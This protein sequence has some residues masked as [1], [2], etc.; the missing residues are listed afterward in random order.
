MIHRLF[1]AG[2]NL[3]NLYL[4]ESGSVFSNGR[5]YRSHLC[6]SITETMCWCQT[7]PV[8]G[9]GAKM[10]F[11]RHRGQNVF[12]APERVLRD[13][14]SSW[15]HQDV[16]VGKHTAKSATIYMR[17]RGGNINCV[18]QQE[19]VLDN[20]TTLHPAWNQYSLYCAGLVSGSLPAS[21]NHYSAVN[22]RLDLKNVKGPFL[23]VQLKPVNVCVWHQ[24]ASVYY[25]SLVPV[26]SPE[27]NLVANQTNGHRWAAEKTIVSET[28]QTFFFLKATLPVL[29]SYSPA[30]WL[31]SHYS[32]TT[33][34][35]NDGD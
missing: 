8:H 14:Y 13:P 31:L 25:D 15:R 3:Q 29:F 30:S 12:P 33:I 26:A 35:E 20:L 10:H 1:V 11:L 18:T 28:G 32:W 5:K 23:G 34:Q 16:S 27:R 24:D 4:S 2:N 17:H 9:T 21:R 22:N 6:S 19:D 7:L